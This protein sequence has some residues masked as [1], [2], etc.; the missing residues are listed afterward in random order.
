LQYRRDL[1]PERCRRMHHVRG[2]C[3]H[4]VVSWREVRSAGEGIAVYRG[5]WVG[6]FGGRWRIVEEWG[7]GAGL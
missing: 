3:V 4:R 7:L 1:A 2:H 5:R 6:R